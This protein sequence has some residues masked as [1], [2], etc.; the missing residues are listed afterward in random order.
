MT[1]PFSP[2]K[3]GNFCI[4]CC[5]EPIEIGVSSTSGWQ[6]SGWNVENGMKIK[7][8]ASG[9]VGWGY[10]SSS[11]DGVYHPYNRVDDRFEHEALLA[12][13]GGGEIFLVGSFY[14]GEPGIGSLEFITNDV[15][16][17]DNSGSYQV[18]IE[19]L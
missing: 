5:P 1:F 10:G 4:K 17:G 18:R 13:V 14:I 16:R 6:S 8:T 3:R 9:S 2:E 11:P 15:V 7:I 19:C 12:R